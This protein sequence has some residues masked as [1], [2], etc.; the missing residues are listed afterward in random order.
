MQ[1]T[2]I[3]ITT[4]TREDGEDPKQYPIGPVIGLLRIQRHHTLRE[5]VAEGIVVQLTT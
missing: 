3:P 5:L 4:D 2:A 1:I